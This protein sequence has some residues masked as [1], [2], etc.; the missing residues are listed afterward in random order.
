MGIFNIFGGKE[1]EA[2]KTAIQNG[3][4]I[5]DVRTSGEFKMG[6]VKGSVNIPLDTV[7]NKVARFKK[8]KQPIVLCCASGNRSGSATNFLK[9]QGIECYNGGSWRSLK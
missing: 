5:V 2:I 8:M 9:S 6:H 4:P 1:K 7:S 3:A